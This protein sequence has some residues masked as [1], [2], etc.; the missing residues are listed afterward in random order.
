MNNEALEG[1]FKKLAK[2]K[3]RKWRITPAGRIR[4]ESL[5]C[6]LNAV[7]GRKGS[8]LH[9]SHSNSFTN[10]LTALGFDGDTVGSIAAAADYN[11]PIY[12]RYN[13][14]LRAR[15][16]QILGLMEPAQ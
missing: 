15:M 8:V 2:T 5:T 10:E 13:K 7:A 6:P 3:N 11:S 14:A 9:K 1:F 16:L 12:Y 4:C